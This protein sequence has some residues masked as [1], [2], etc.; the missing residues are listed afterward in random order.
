MIFQKFNDFHYCM[1]EDVNELKC[2]N[3]H[4]EAKLSQ[5]D[6]ENEE[7]RKFKSLSTALSFKN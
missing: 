3:S 5:L 4:L 7:L 1:Q 2:K 6:D